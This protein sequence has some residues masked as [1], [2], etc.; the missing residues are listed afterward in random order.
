MQSPLCGM[1]GW[2]HLVLPSGPG[3]PSLHFFQLLSLCSSVGSCW[4][5][6]KKTLNRHTALGFTSGEQG[7]HTFTPASVEMYL[8][9]NG[10][11]LL[12]IK[13]PNIDFSQTWVQ[14]RSHSNSIGPTSSSVVLKC[15]SL[16][17]TEHPN[18][19]PLESTNR[20]HN[21]QQHCP[22]KSFFNL[23]APLLFLVFFFQCMLQA[24]RKWRAKNNEA[25][26][27][28]FHHKS[29]PR[30]PAAHSGMRGLPHSPGASGK[31]ESDTVLF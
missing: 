14:Y 3:H 18:T 31:A 30:A 10:S 24:G 27:Y 29:C 5:G 21:Y 26:S 6:Y 28:H 17:L 20:T 23:Q 7:T 25:N 19:S 9:P 2:M 8:L 13:P 1:I 22:K 4:T 15:L 16:S 12:S 11:P